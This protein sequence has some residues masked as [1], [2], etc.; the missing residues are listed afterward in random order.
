MVADNGVRG[1]PS[2]RRLW[3]AGLVAVGLFAAGLAGAS[4]AS[5]TTVVTHSAKAGEFKALG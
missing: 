4:D 1:E 5:A 3:V 2:W